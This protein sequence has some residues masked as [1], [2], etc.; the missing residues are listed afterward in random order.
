M[1]LV[2]H[3]RT[4]V[5][6]VGPAE[7]CTYELVYVTD[8]AEI[9]V[10]AAWLATRPMLGLDLETTGLDWGTDEIIT[11][12]IGA[13]GPEPRVYVIDLRCMAWDDLQPIWDLC[14]SR[15]HRKLGMNIGFEARFLGFRGV[16]LRH[17]ADI[18]LTE[19]VLRAGLFSTKREGRGSDGLDRAGYSAT[20]M[21][22]LA[23]RYLGITIDK[24]EDLR[25][26]FGKSRPGHL[27]ERQLAYAADD[28]ILPFFIFQQQQDELRERELGQIVRIEFEALPVIAAAELRG[29]RIDVQAWLA[30]WQE[31]LQERADAERRLDNRFRELFPQGELFTDIRYRPVDTKTGKPVKYDSPEQVKR[32][33]AAYCAHIRWPVEIVI[34]EARIQALKE[35]HGQEWLRRRQERE[36]DAT[37]EDVPLYMLP[38]SVLPLVSTEADAL[39]LARLTKQLPKDLVEDLLTFSSASHRATA[40]G[41]GFLDRNLDPDGRIRPTFHQ[42]LT[43]TGRLSSSDP[44]LQ[45]IPSD[46]RYRTCFVPAP[47]YKFVILDYSQIEP[48][49]SAQVSR[50]PVYVETFRSGKDIYLK[51]GEAMLGHPIDRHTPEGEIQRAIFKAMVL[52]LAYRMGPYKLWTTL[53]LALE[54]EILDGTIIAPTREEVYDLHK[55]FFEVHAGIA[56][57]QDK[58]GE[59]ADPET[60]PKLYDR[61]L[62]APV[63][64]VTAP[65]GRKRYFTPD[66]KSTYTEGPNA[67]IQGCSAT[68][69]KLAAALVQREIDRDGL[70]ATVINLVHDEIV[71]EV[72]DDQAAAFATRAQRLMEEAAARFIPDIPVAAAFPENTTGVVDAWLKKGKAA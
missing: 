47:G 3:T 60:G 11:V 6:P 71:W 18:Q 37:V 67:P 12:Q 29:M 65:C 45:N 33:I 17:V 44:N 43:S 22:A 16:P 69:T 21:L 24:D 8:P 55:R 51:V 40:F 68:I 5:C 31:A 15:E 2:S 38:H 10:A 53:L 56:A 57:Y 70:D 25:T 19:L 14:V 23:K 36:P 52:A 46:P 64:W 34:D 1:T 20:S 50:D 7:G 42:V 61:Y 32:L 62:D 48:R 27:S 35:E 58:M 54:Q 13:L 41:K 39:R 9:P 49:L 4:R 72:R 66:A 30:L 63:T 26:S 28:V 59:L